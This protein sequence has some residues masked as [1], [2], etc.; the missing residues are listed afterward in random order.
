MKDFIRFQM[1]VIAWALLIFWLS[2]IKSIPSIRFPIQLDKVAHFSIFFILCW[3]SRRAFDFQES[4]RWLKKQALLWAFIFSC[5]Y[6]Y[7]DEFHQRFVPGRTYDYYD[8]LADA[9][10][11]LSFVLLFK[12][13]E[14][15]RNQRREKALLS[16]HLT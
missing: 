14:R 9:I 13:T 1:P 2:S 11:A 7:F 10:G 16:E 12:L 4:I 8:M 5:I 15:W 3:F 6:G